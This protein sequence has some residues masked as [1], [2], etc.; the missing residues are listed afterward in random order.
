MADRALRGLTA[1]T[2]EAVLSSLVPA[3]AAALDG[4]GPALLPLPSGGTR[5]AV[6]EALRP[7]LPLERD[8]VALVVPT[9]GSTG[10]PKGALLTAAALRHS[11][12]A[13]HAR[14][15]G[16]GQWLLALPVT[17]I[18]GLAVLVRALEARTRPEVLDL[19]GGFDVARFAAAA[20]RLDAG[21]RR[22]T[23]LVPTQLRRLLDAGVDLTWF[24]AVLVGGAAL[25][26]DL[27]RVAGAA[28]VRVVTTYGMSETC[29]GCVYDGRPLDGVDVALAP[30]GRISLGGPVVFAGYRLR[31]DLTSAALVDGRH[32]TQDLG[33]L[34]P[35]G[36]LEVLGRADDVIV[37]GGE[38][39]AAGLVERVLGDHPGVR[40]CAVVGRPDPEWGERVVAVVEARD[41]DDVPSLEELRGVAAGSLEAAALPRELVVLGVLPMLPS[42]KPDKAAVRTLVAAR[43]AP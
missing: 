14:L 37:T 32:V 33:R 6:L 19:Y 10:E 17:H 23:A 34:G 8:D 42:G 3:L 21:R 16:P 41:W 4:A 11:A 9:S 24:D 22:Y 12:R 13:T 43:P 35:D 26:A 28:G 39:V 30:D 31:P 25:P 1:P 20:A 36:R 38:N 2:G 18:A 15:G 29:G 5:R 40:A 7:D 27:H